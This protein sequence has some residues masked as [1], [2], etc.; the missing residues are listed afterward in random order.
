MEITIKHHEHHFKDPSS[1]I[2]LTV[3]TDTFSVTENV[4]EV[5]GNVSIELIEKLREI[6]NEFEMQNTKVTCAKI[7]LKN[8]K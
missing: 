5:N 8:K 7:F 2:E 3:R 4:T 1:L 6:A